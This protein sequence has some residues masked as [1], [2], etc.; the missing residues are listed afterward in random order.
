MT[1]TLSEA[2]SQAWDF[3]LEES[4][5]CDPNDDKVPE[6]HQ[7]TVSETNS[8]VGGTVQVHDSVLNGRPKLPESW[9]AEDLFK[10]KDRP[11]LFPESNYHNDKSRL[12]LS[13]GM[14][15]NMEAE[16][17]HPLID[18]LE[19]DLFSKSDLKSLMSELD[20]DSE[21]L[22]N[23]DEMIQADLENAEVTFDEGLVASET[24]FQE[25]DDEPKSGHEHAQILD[26]VDNPTIGKIT[27]I[28]GGT[29]ARGDGDLPDLEGNGGNFFSSSFQ[30]DTYPSNIDDID[31]WT[32]GSN[33][34]RQSIV[35]SQT[36]SAAMKKMGK[37]RNMH[38]N[39]EKGCWEGGGEQLIIDEDTGQNSKT[40]SINN[41][42][43]RN[44]AAVGDLKKD[45]KG[46]SI[47]QALPLASAEKIAPPASTAVTLAERK[48]SPATE[49][50]EEV[51]RNAQVGLPGEELAHIA[52]NLDQPR[53]FLVPPAILPETHGLGETRKALALPERSR[54][55]SVESFDHPM[56]FR[57][58]L[59]N[60]A[61]RPVT[62]ASRE[63]REA[64]PSAAVEELNLQGCGLYT[65]ES[66]EEYTTDLI[67]L[68][69]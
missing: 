34:T 5:K 40:H 63:T 7:A 9:E 60:V 42:P 23:K 54:G 17:S 3:E 33:S 1:D 39:E 69:A 6:E 41:S 67:R 44:L 10:S 13:V 66:L 27:N 50:I 19:E 29:R 28:P 26:A 14:A 25:K 51:K 68:D 21:L 20:I 31:V 59:A 48:I 46:D 56:R 35:Q 32:E 49:K 12:S 18:A 58:P 24:K 2:L 47:Q 55:S 57:V 36:L 37:D 4:L 38:F 8:V 30:K 52:T 45:F 11:P 16:S 53:R 64:T 62:F 22:D 65:L 61:E 43:S 15:A